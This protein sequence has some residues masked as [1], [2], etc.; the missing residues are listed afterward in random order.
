[1]DVLLIGG[2]ATERVTVGYTNR[3]EEQAFLG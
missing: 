1:M 3:L 2:L